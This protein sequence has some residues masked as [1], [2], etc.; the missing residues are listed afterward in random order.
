MTDETL[1][2][3]KAMEL[4]KKGNGHTNPNPLVGAVIVKNN[5]IISEGYHECF[6]GLHAEI[7]AFTQAKE[8]V[9]GATMYVTLEPC[10]HY[11]KTPPCAL[12][13]IEKGIK[14]VVVGMLD[15]NPLV[16]GKGIAMLK[17]H[18][19]EVEV[20]ILEVEIMKMNEIF[21]KYI[22]T[23]LPFC[24]LKTAMTLDGKIATVS[25]E[26]KWISCKQSRTQVHQLR[27]QV[28]AIM[29]GVQTVLIDNP[30]LSTRLDD[31]KISHPL[32]IIVDSKGRVP[33][34]SKVMER[35]SNQKTLIATT[36]Q[37]SQEKRKEI[38]ENGHQ[39]IVCPMKEAGVDL[40]YL[41]AQ[42]GMMGIDSVLIEGGSTLNF[43]ALKEGIVD[44]VI[45]YIAP[46]IIGGQ[47]AIT[48]IGGGGITEL[49]ESI[50]LKNIQ[51]SK[52]G[53]DIRLEGY[54]KEV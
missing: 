47:T 51:V 41:M 1:Y 28:G 10:S 26:S 25:G 52:V 53:D 39:V 2:M 6:G 54:L 30:T 23:Q 24:I 31:V 29:V 48:P 3:K 49:K 42:L 15:P 11:G 7:N 38:E 5:T 13:I 12:A 19:I 40:K 34:D 14:K 37:M 43:S 21:I 22:S 45:T 9:E 46:M 32:R 27:Q 50:K 4:A 18:G 8:S 33:V 16:S 17:E 36:H 35:C 20:G 44:K